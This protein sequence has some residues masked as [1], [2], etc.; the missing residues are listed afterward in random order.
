MKWICTGSLLLALAGTP[1]LC[2]AQ[3]TPAGDDPTVAPEALRQLL[4]TSGGA[5][6]R[7]QAPIGIAEITPDE[8]GGEKFGKVR[9]ER[10]SLA[11]A[12]EALGEAANAN[13]VVSRSVADQ[14]ITITLREIDLPSALDAIAVS[15][16]LV[17]RR[18]DASGVYFLATPDE[19]QRDLSAFRANETEVFTL[20]YPNATDVVRAIGDVFGERVIVTEPDD[21]D[22]QDRTDLENRFQRF[23]ILEG[24]SRGLS[25]T[26]TSGGTNVVSGSNLS[27]RL[28]NNRSNDNRNN[29][30]TGPPPRFNPDDF[31]DLTAEEARAVQQ[32]LAGAGDATTQAQALAIARRDALTYVTSIPRLNRI[33]V[34]SSDPQVLEDIRSLIKRVDVPTP[35]VLLEVRVLRVILDDGLNS[36]FDFAFQAG[37]AQGA[38]SSGE[39][40]VPGVGS[41][42][43][44]GTGANLSA[45]LF[46]VV[47][48]NFQ[49]RIELLQSKGRVTSLATPILLT[50]NGEVSRIFSGEQIPITIGFTEPQ[51]I[52]GDGATTTL[53]AT[54]VTELRDVGTDLLITANINADRT[55][56]LR[57]LQETS[58]INEDGASILVPSG[59]AFI[60]ET[61]DTVAS[62]SASGT[63]VAQDGKL[64]AF[65]GLIEETETDTREQLPLLGDLPMVG[66]L[67]RRESSLISRS[68]L[69]VMVRPYV[70]STPVEGDTISRNLLESLSIHPYRPGDGAASGKPDEWGVFRDKQ[71]AFDRSLFDQFRFHTTPAVDGGQP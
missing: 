18:D 36:E 33:I 1:H 31:P 62:Q 60:T 53:S 23:D 9:L 32:A 7:P 64:L 8:D 61:V 46:Q 54:P 52:V 57:L 28:N 56:T 35:L 67:F 4:D 25:S 16:G 43:P 21:E 24:R 58:T 45:G 69:I 5:N 51:V 63:I 15:Q 47:S 17:A 10:V 6:R 49:A 11:Q 55:V 38:F 65:G 13:V 59:S 71:P 19:I 14:P 40:A 50:A 34:R 27:S 66:F 41:I 2:L 3:D 29:N 68:E 39:I 20:L 70:L 42:L 12:A 26:S 22:D 44:S 48:D 30:N 37:D